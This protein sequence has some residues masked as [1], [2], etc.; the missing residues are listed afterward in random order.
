MG[1]PGPGP[2]VPLNPALGGSANWLINIWFG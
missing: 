2:F 1:D